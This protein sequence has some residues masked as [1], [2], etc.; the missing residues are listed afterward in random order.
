MEFPSPTKSVHHEMYEAIN[1]ANP[2]LSAKD[3]TIFI[4]GG[5]SSIGVAT[6]KAFAKAG[7]TN[8]A[9]TGRTET[10]LW[11]A[12]EAIEDEFNSVKITP[13][14]A[15]V[16]DQAA[17]SRAFTTIGT[18]DILVNNAGYMPDLV[19]VKDA[20]LSEWWRGFEIN[21]KGSFIVTQAFLRVASASATIV[22]VTAGMV[23][24]PTP[25]P[26]YSSYVSS[27]IA[28]AKFFQLMQQE[29]PEMRVIN[30]HPGVIQSAMLE[31]APFIEAQDDGNIA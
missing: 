28:S 21:V 17:I 15:D 2:I 24:T 30:V 12:K 14:V 8:I 16:T 3:K 25:F 7:A 6:V 20:I 31:K 10:T 1:P 19:P 18:V 29:H 4:T 27:K 9:I 11:R 26:G 22:N 13:I 23:H 5:G